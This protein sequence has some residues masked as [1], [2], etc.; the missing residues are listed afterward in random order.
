MLLYS[1]GFLQRLLKQKENFRNI[2]FSCNKRQNWLD[3]IMLL[4]RLSAGTHL[5]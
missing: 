1:R 5:R 4:S 3:F 2:G